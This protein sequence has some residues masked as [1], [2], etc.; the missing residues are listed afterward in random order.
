MVFPTEDSSILYVFAAG[1]T[2]ILEF[3]PGL[4][5]ETFIKVHCSD[6]VT[7]ENH[8]KWYEVAIERFKDYPQVEVIKYENT[9]IVNIPILA[10]RQF[11]LAFVDN[12][13]GANNKNRV[14]H[15]GQ[16]KL[17]RWNTLEFCMNHCNLVFL[18]DCKRSG[19][20]NSLSRAKQ[21]GW[22]V[23]EYP[24]KRGLAKLTNIKE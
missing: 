5:T 17:A 18:H 4:S 14:I 11:E 8:P 23:Y 9:P 20:Q 22:E 7:C 3:G 1:L 24:T 13:V 16:E 2:S 21:L 6:I 10:N 15:K 12:P 19:E